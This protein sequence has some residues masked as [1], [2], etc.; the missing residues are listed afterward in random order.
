MYLVILLFSGFL[1]AV[2]L[3]GLVYVEATW[4]GIPPSGRLFGVG[5]VGLGS[6]GGFLVPYRFTAELVYLYFQVF[7]GSGVASHPSEFLVVSLVTGTGISIGLAL[8]Y[9][10]TSRLWYSR[11]QTGIGTG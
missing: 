3:S 7:K 9:V 1:T 5:F 8:L 6:L 11:I 2:L 4:R 10:A